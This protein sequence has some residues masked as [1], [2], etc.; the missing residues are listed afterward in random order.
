DA[1]GKVHALNCYHT[2]RPDFLGH[3]LGHYLGAEFA[4]LPLEPFVKREPQERMPLYHLVGA[5]DPLTPGDVKQPVGDGLPETLGEWIPF[6]GLTHIKVKLNGD[7]LGWDVER[8]VRV[9]AISA[10]A[11]AARGVDR[12]HY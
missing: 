9:D 5:L 8:V 2:Y 3:D 12:W 1:F 7:D 11:Q 10:K 4:G 6:N